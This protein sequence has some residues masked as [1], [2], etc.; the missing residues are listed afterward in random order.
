MVLSVLK[1]PS[2]ERSSD[3][4]P[5]PTVRNSSAPSSAPETSS[6]YLADLDFFSFLIGSSAAL[7]EAA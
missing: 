1:T 3:L 4:P 2:L 7:F 6:S 5:L